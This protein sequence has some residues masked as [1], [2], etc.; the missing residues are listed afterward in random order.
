[1]IWGINQQAQNMQTI[2]SLSEKEIRFFLV[3]KISNKTTLVNSQQHNYKQIDELQEYCNHWVKNNHCK[4]VTCH[5]LLS[6]KL[7]NAF[8]INRPKVP[9]VELEDS[10]KWLVKDQIE[11][12][13]DKILT[14]HYLPQLRDHNAEKITAIVVDKNLVENLIA[15]TQDSGMNLNSIQINELTPIHTFSDEIT[16]NSNHHEKITGYIDEDNQGL[17]FNFYVGQSLAF[18]RHIKGRYFPSSSEKDLLLDNENLQDKQ[19][20]FLLETQRTLD[21]CVSQVFRKPVDSLVLDSNKTNDDLSTALQQLTELPIVRYDIENKISISEKNNKNF[22]L[23]TFAE[24]GLFLSQFQQPS[25]SINFY[26]NQYRPKPLEFG[27]KFA[28]SI[29][30]I[31]ILVFIGYGLIQ[32]HEEN[33]LDDKLATK[34]QMLLK[35]QQALQSIQMKRTGS[36]T[37][38]DINQ[39]IL[40]KQNR[41]LKNKKLLKNVTN[42]S[43]LKTKKYSEVLLALS[44]IKTPSLWLTNIDI[45]L[46]KISLGGQTTQ[47]ESIPQYINQM[48][49]NEALRQQFE[50]LKIERD[51]GNNQ[52]VNFLISN[53]KIEYA[54]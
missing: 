10:I 20:Q 46:D 6:R 37:I 17:I 3:D 34:K 21:Y 5:W 53:G 14:R 26:L 18:T 36:R 23:L 15:M 8:T 12:P 39:Q 31:F 13:L 19:N 16:S 52:L 41:L 40:I 28:T 22:K 42:L 29:A 27:F 1:M 47:P 9:D 24:A 38:V 54:N 50:E 35:T 32:N 33:L 11:Q 30:A 44:Q 45:S 43:V 25:Q 51:D 7:Y 49:K 2:I 4:N 48:A